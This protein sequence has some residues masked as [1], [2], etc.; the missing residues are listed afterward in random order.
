M[1]IHYNGNAKI[2]FYIGGKKLIKKGISV[3]LL[4]PFNLL[5]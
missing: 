1:A 2:L 3:I 4:M 5:F